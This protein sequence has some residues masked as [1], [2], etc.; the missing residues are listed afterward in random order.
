MNKKNSGFFNLS[1]N[2]IRV[3]LI[4]LAEILFF[5]MAFC[6]GM[7]Y[8]QKGSINN[9]ELESL[10]MQENEQNDNSTFFNSLT[11]KD[12]TQKEPNASLVTHTENNTDTTETE[13]DDDQGKYTIQAFSFRSK[14]T[15]IEIAEDLK[16]RGHDAH[17]TS[18]D[19]GN[20][21]VWHRVM[22][23]HYTSYEVAKKERDKIKQIENI[24]VFITKDE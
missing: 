15:A 9:Q 5:V 11:K 14:K 6:L 24:D 2:R 1:N 20:S 18:V 23:G 16:R 10:I 13:A 12:E 21:G 19:L 3:T 4:V 7:L 8:E 22:I 17:T